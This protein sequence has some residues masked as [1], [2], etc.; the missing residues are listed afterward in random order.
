MKPEEFARYVDSQLRQ[1][2]P[3][4]S[5]VNNLLAGGWTQEQI[6][7][8]FAVHEKIVR[9]ELSPTRA[10]KYTKGEIVMVIMLIA[11]ILLTCLFILGGE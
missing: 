2:I 7:S 5:L 8:A 1:D 11:F 9:K 6:D 10:H 3:K 4:S